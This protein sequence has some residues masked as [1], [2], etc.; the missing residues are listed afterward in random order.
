METRR[1]SW[2]AAGCGCLVA[3]G[4]G[5][6]VMGAIVA[7]VDG[8]GEPANMA[9]TG[10]CMGV[11][12]LLGLAGVILGLRKKAVDPNQAVQAAAAQAMASGSAFVDV[13]P[14]TPPGA[15]VDA[16]H[17]TFG[18]NV[19]KAWDHATRLLTSRRYEEAKQAFEHIAATS[20]ERRPDALNSLGACLHMMRRYAE[21]I[22]TYEQAR[23]AG[24]DP[25]TID[26]N[27]AES[28]A[29]MR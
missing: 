15:V 16:F 6:M 13:P 1:A 3:M 18:G 17:A 28:R 8:T 7:A 12:V 26:E 11:V 10:A 24:A 9:V 20:P 5:V 23:A 27:I 25:R 14:G 19:D 4:A 2:L 21:A 29:A 22:A